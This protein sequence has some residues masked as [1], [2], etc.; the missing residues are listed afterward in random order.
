[1]HVSPREVR[2][3]LGARKP[4]LTA[5]RRQNTAVNGGPVP[6]GASFAA[7][8]E[9]MPRPRKRYL[10]RGCHVPVQQQE[11]RSY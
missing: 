8:F 3:A 10:Q 6:K 5:S 1:M 7:A 11:E 2:S 9:V 4:K